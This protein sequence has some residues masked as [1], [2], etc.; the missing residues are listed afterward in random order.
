[1]LP[2]WLKAWW[3]VFGNDYEPLVV[4]VRKDREIIGIAPLKRRSGEVSFAGDA[5]VCDY[6]D[7]IVQ[8]GSEEEF[9]AVLLDWLP[10]HGT[11][12]LVLETLRPDSMVLQGFCAVAGKRG[13]VASCSQ[14]G[15]SLE[16][17]LPDTW[18]G[19]LASL[20]SRQRH[21]IERKSRKLSAM[22][23]AVFSVL[24]DHE[25]TAEAME[26]FLDMMAQSRRDKFAFMT[27]EMR[28]YFKTLV[29]NLAAYGVVR[30]GFLKLGEIRV[31]A[32]LFFDYNNRIYL[33]NSGYNPD[34]A[35]LSAGLM[36]KLFCVHE[37]IVDKK[38]V[39]DFLKGAEIYKSRL[40][41]HE[42]ML[43]ICHLHL[44]R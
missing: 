43:S 36:S 40:G 13:W 8:P 18:D 9:S 23:E 11:K 5:S 21:D 28:S 4:A 14:A 33:Y 25:I 29:K 6:A 2:G 26:T 20:G 7:F 22:G 39:F 15:V 31:A 19:Y 16:M 24:K 35:A 41:G 12:T 27:P 17:A 1:M 3:A 34:Y 32:V 42:I 10:L 38:K 44:S 30:L 37:A